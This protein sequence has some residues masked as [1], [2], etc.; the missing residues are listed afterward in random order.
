[1][2]NDLQLLRAY[3]ANGSEDAFAA[4]LERHLGLVYS[5]ALR[6]VRDPHLAEE[7]AQ[8][9]F[10]ILAR[11]AGS[12]R[13]GTV[14][15]GWLFRA[16][17]FA[18]ARAVRGEQRRQ[19]REQEAAPMN[20]PA[21]EPAWEEV[22][23]I[24]DD[25]IAALSETDRN[26]ILLRFFERKELKEVGQALGSSEEAAKK[27]VARAL[28]KLRAFLTRRGVELT[29]TVLTSAL[30]VN[31]VH[32]APPGLSIS[33]TAAV[34][35]NGGTAI[36]TLTLIQ[37]TM[38]A[39][40]YAQFKTAALIVAFVLGTVAAGSLLAQKAARPARP[41]ADAAAF[42]RATPLGALRHFA[43]AVLDADSRATMDG[44]HARSPAATNFVAAFG[45]AVAAEA[46]FR[47]TVSRR[48]GGKPVRLVNV[49]FGQQLLDDAGSIDGT[50]EYHG[51]NRASIRLT[52]LVDGEPPHV[53]EMIRSGGVWRL[54]EEDI[55][56]ASDG[57]T[58]TTRF[59]RDFARKITEA[60]AEVGAGRYGSFEEMSR[61]LQRKVASVSRP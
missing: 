50:V 47:K 25:A 38:K 1:M 5:A 48:F 19:R 4:V 43:R 7:I 33:V 6:Q 22:A 40:F 20:S 55:P 56:G 23:P 9:V 36:A 14:L 10:V 53:L 44:I 59:F 51:T 42:D 28:D 37:A 60:E 17:R 39:M 26:A 32:A 46:S 35:A 21:S 11:K 41:A 61:A 30:I 49:N 18:A 12:L 8:A 3:A 13:D 2:T 29:T 58:N 27:R 31:A 24:L 52:A 15:S 34:A 54:G 16:T 45:S 57:V